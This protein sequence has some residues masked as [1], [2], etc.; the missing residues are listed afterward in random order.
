MKI[1]ETV[2]CIDDSNGFIDYIDEHGFE[3]VDE[4]V[5]QFDD[6]LSQGYIVKIL[7]RSYGINIKYTIDNYTYLLDIDIN[8]GRAPTNKIGK[9]IVEKLISKGAVTVSL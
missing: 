6:L 5:E 3:S 2:V 8:S 1:T 7:S 4:Y 9:E